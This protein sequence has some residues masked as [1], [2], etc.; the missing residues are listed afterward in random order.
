LR[1]PQLLRSHLNH[2]AQARRNAGAADR[3]HHSPGVLLWLRKQGITSD[4]W[5]DEF[6][7]WLEAQGLTRPIK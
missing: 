4:H 6:Y 2:R 7:W 3:D 5:I 1:R